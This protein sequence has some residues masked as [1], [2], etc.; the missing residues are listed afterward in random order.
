[1][2]PMDD[3]LARVGIRHP[4][5][6]APMAG[7][8]TP[9]L[10]AAVSN[11]GG[12]GS[13]GI[14]ASTPAAIRASFESVRAMTAR[15]VNMNVFCHRRPDRCADA[16]AAW[17]RHLAPLFDAFGEPVPTTLDEIYP[18]FLD[19]RSRLDLLLELRAD[20]VSFHFGLPPVAW[21][22]ALRDAG[23]FTMATATSPQEAGWIEQAGVDAIVAQGSEA[24]GHRG[25]F[26]PAAHDE[27]L[28]TAVLVRR[29]VKR[30]WLP[31]IASGGIMD[32]AGI[33]AMLDLGA[34]AVQLGTA[35]VA[36]PESSAGAGYRAMLK[37]ARAGTT[38]MT[39]AISGRPARGIVNRLVE[40]GEAPGAPRIP[41][42]PVAYDAG[43][44][45]AAA[46]L[47]RGSA[48]CSALWAGQ[49]APLVRELPAA[50]LV[51]TLMDELDEAASRG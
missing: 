16:E 31:V 14:G 22:D 21:I 28:P 46:A 12:L 1:M 41:P 5:I 33:R 25:V 23:V 4:L 44:R 32:G 36:C 43:K 50:E 8:S 18:S 9:A 10:A 42:Y 7:V 29:L 47:R 24:G 49:G 34:V 30:S 2:K 20:V 27:A 26:D 39:S 37:S 17:A 15:P 38:R 11:A 45:L 40:L 35:F 19:D 13:L 6:Q 3:F 51:S 48:E